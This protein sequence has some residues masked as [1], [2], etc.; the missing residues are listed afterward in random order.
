MLLLSAAVIAL[1]FIEKDF[2]GDMSNRLPY[3]INICNLK[4]LAAGVRP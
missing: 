3:L 4:F 2:T 1:R